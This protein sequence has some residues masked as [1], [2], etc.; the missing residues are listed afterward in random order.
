MIKKR[1]ANVTYK[2][3]D[4]KKIPKKE[5]EEIITKKVLRIILNNKE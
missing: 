5:L 3:I 4:D 2:V 1:K